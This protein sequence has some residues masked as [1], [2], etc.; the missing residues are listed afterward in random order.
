M[1]IKELV[2]IKR[3]LLEKIY[4][5]IYDELEGM[6]DTHNQYYKYVQNL[7]TEVKDVLKD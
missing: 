3:E 5:H 6:D 4:Y 7:L 2:P 1:M